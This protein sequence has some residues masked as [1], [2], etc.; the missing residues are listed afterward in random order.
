[1]KKVLAIIL[2]F[3]ALCFSGCESS[4]QGFAFE[5]N[6]E[7]TKITLDNFEGKS[8]SGINLEN[9]GKIIETYREETSLFANKSKIDIVNVNNKKIGAGEVAGVVK[10]IESSGKTIAIVL[11]DRVDFFDISGKYLNTL[12]ISGKYKSLCLY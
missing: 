1:M 10:S 8:V 3:C 11:A 4:D 12:S 9:E 2:I 5:Q 6:D 7:Y